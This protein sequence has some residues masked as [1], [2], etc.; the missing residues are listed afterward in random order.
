LLTIR[1]NFSDDESNFYYDRITY[2]ASLLL[3]TLVSA[4]DLFK[5]LLKEEGKKENSNNSAETNTIECDLCGKHFKKREYPH[6][7]EE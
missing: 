3:S 6:C 4:F 5:N 7:K 1:V 2:S